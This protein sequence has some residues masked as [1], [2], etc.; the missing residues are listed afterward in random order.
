MA[1]KRSGC[2]K[3][4]CQVPEAPI[5]MPRSTIFACAVVV[6]FTVDLFIRGNGYF[7]ASSLMYVAAWMYLSSDRVDWHAQGLAGERPAWR[8]RLPRRAAHGR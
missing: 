1:T 3:P 4:R 5:D 6:S 8:A 7:T 2:F